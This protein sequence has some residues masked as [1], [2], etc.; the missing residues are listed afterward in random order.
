MITGTYGTETKRKGQYTVIGYNW[1][2]RKIAGTKA[3]GRSGVKEVKSHV[4]QRFPHRW[5]RYEVY[6]YR[7]QKWIEG[8]AQGHFK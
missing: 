3:Y 4:R 6:S 2:G 5:K 8:K 1:H 7:S